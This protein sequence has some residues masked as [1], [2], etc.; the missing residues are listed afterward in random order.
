M[1]EKS[2]EYDVVIIGAG[3]IG[4]AVSRWLSFYDLKV[5]VLE[6]EEDICS[7][8]SK[9]N[10]AIV[11]A[12]HDAL[13]GTMKA[14]MNIRGS[15]MMED[16]S[17]ELNFSYR[18]NGALVLSFNKEDN[19]KLEEL[20]QRGLTNGV[21]GLEI[22]DAK[23]VHE[24]DLNLSD[25]VVAALYCPTSAIVCPFDLTAAFAENACANG[26]KYIFNTKVDS[27]VK[28]GDYYVINGIFKTKAIV[29]AAG[30]YSDTIHNMVC[31]E[32]IQI[33]ARKGDYYIFDKELGDYVSHTIFQLPSKM[34][35]GVLVTPTVHGNLLIGPSATVVDDKEFTSPTSE[36]LTNIIAA[37]RSS[38]KDIYMNKVIT[39]FSG[40]RAHE[41]NSDFIIK[42]SANNFFD[43]AGIE[44][45]G[46]TCAPA[47]GE[48]VSK[49]VADKLKVTLKDN[50]IKDRK[51][52][53]KVNTLSSEERSKL[54]KENPSYGN[55]IC[56]CEQVSEGEIIDAINRTPGAVSFDG[57]K[58]RV[59]VGM[60]R[61]QSGFCFSKVIKILSRELH[62]DVTEINKNTEGSYMVYKKRDD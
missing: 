30:L 49:M 9:A 61:C 16:L 1:I 39:S 54:I 23:R 8:T 51:G 59:R 58:R 40:L 52:I 28:D 48:Y 25:N 27:I 10:S 42:E 44:S 60:G 53:L 6:K 3:V 47:I 26:C 46:L 2:R 37:A 41:I 4:T 24:L 21:K 50:I 20:Y 62:K 43:C 5:L 22:I 57:V 38:V 32:K 36:D 15:L 45:P 17:K 13:P 12:G 19:Y 34:G 18:R 7:G 29:N 14:K 11:H 33:E 55:I 56:R 35:K 31:D